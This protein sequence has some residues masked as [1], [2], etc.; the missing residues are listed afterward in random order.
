MMRDPCNANE[1]V[2]KVG[3]NTPGEGCCM[4]TWA[5]EFKPRAIL[6]IGKTSM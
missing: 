3:I 5:E 4:D 2:P 1:T 6:S